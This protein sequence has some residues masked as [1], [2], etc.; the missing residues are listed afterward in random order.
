MLHENKEKYY[1]LRVL[2]C[3][4]AEPGELYSDTMNAC[5]KEACFGITGNFW[6]FDQ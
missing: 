2:D 3:D 5:T 1:S 4:M 6:E